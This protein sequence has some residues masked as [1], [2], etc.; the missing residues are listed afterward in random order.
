MLPFLRK[1][2]APSDLRATVDRLL[3]E[4]RTLIELRFCAAG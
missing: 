2:F 1:P 4:H 3:E